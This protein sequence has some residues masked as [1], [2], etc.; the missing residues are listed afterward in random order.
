MQIWEDLSDDD[1][2]LDTHTLV[3]K[4]CKT[5][6]SGAKATPES[7]AEN[8]KKRAMKKK[9]KKVSLLDGKR[10][11]NGGIQMAKLRLNEKVS[12]DV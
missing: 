10:Q 6:K 5:E 9:P 11:Q 7:T 12:H 3:N 1:V 2:E 4:F 8:E